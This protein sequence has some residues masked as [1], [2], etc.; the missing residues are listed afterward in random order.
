[1]LLFP[2]A[3]HVLSYNFLFVTT[4][5]LLVYRGMLYPVPVLPTQ[6]LLTIVVIYMTS[7]LPYFIHSPVLLHCLLPMPRPHPSRTARL[8]AARISHLESSLFLQLLYLFPRYLTSLSTY[9]IFVDRL[10]ETLTT[11]NELVVLA[12]C[13]PLLP[14]SS[15][16]VN[17]QMQPRLWWSQSQVQI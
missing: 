9:Q 17:L 11:H 16:C 7:W 3:H 14:L 15:Y 1:M 6:W 8:P 5:V 13:P 4:D 2:F 12:V 10:S